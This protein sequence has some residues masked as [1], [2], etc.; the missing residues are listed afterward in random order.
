MEGVEKNNLEGFVEYKMT[1]RGRP[2][3]NRQETGDF[4][5]IERIIGALEMLSACEGMM[6][7]KGMAD[8]IKAMTWALKDLK[9]GTKC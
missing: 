4:N 5:N 1:K 3:K 7:T 9:G 8:V 6:I 2:R